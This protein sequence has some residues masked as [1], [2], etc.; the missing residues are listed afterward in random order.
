MIKNS[1]TAITNIKYLEKDRNL[2]VSSKSKNIKVWELPLFWRD[3][4]I[5]EEEE[6]ENKIRNKTEKM[7][8]MQK[9]KIV[10][11]QDSDEDELANF[12]F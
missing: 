8:D 2:I 4:K 7:I 3:K 5:E 10:C 11:E 1:E 9:K 12:R 6:M